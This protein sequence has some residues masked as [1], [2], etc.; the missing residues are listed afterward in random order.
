MENNKEQAAALVA[1]LK[2]V[3]LL[4]CHHTLDEKA[5]INWARCLTELAPELTPQKLKAIIDFMKLGLLEFSDSK[6]ITNIFDG[7]RKCLLQKIDKSK[8]DEEEVT[9]LRNELKKLNPI[10]FQTNH[11]YI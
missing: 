9:R 4:T 3:N 6:G 5:L 10:S 7:Y 8:M 1:E 2:E 11:Y